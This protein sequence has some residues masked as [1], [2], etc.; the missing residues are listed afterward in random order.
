MRI[1]WLIPTAALSGSKMK[2]IGGQVGSMTDLGFMAVV[3]N[4]EA[5][6][7]FALCSGSLIAPNVVLT[8]AHCVRPWFTNYRDTT[9]DPAASLVKVVLG[10][11]NAIN[12]DP[13]SHIIDVSKIVYRGYGSNIR[14]P[15]DG[16]VALLELDQC[17]NESP[18]LIEYAKVATWETEPDRSGCVNITVAGYGLVSNVPPPLYENDGKLRFIKDKLLS[19]SVCRA[20]Y[21]AL[22]QGFQE[23][24]ALDLNNVPSNVADTVLGDNIICSGGASFHSVCFGDSGGPSF[25]RLDNGKAQVIATT[26]FGYGD[27]NYCS[28]GPDFNTRTAFYADWIRDQ[29]TNEINLCPNWSIDN[30][31]ASSS[32]YPESSLSSDWKRSRCAANEWQCLS[33]QCISDSLVCNGL[34]QCSDESDESFSRDGTSLCGSDSRLSSG[35]TSNRRLIRKLDNVNEEK[36]TT[37]NIYSSTVVACS[38]AISLVD[39]AVANVKS[40]ETTIGDLYWDPTDLLS[41]CHLLNSCDDSGIFSSSRYSDNKRVCDAISD[42]YTW[43]LKND[44]YSKTFGQVY[45]ASCP[46]DEYINNQSDSPVEVPLSTTT[47]KSSA[48][49]STLFSV[50]IALGIGALTTILNW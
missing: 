7:C 8:A 15:S 29:I 43:T 48:R 6:S 45:G 9:T 14:F 33:G 42:W 17:I 36:F 5:S 22:E 18:G 11:A 12:F 41:A 28:L 2:I 31:F 23:P 37:Q 30:S 38:T 40:T 27:K 20:A 13:N 46:D 4:C 47:T 44:Q 34:S 19:P 21:A 39:S 25:T 10:T 26:S 50:L 24:T 49:T 1:L 35:N 32:S 3:L 16:D